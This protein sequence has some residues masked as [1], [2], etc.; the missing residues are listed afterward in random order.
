MIQKQL[1]I[2]YCDYA[3]LSEL[4][5]EWQPLVQEARGAADSAYA[6]YSRFCVGAAVLLGDG[7]IVTG[8]NQENAAYPSGLC[9][10]RVALFSAMH[11][12]PCCP[13]RA[14]AVAGRDA[15][16]RYVEASPCGACR[17]VMAEAEG[18][19]GRPMV[20]LICL[21]GGE[22]RL[23]RGTNSLLPFAFDALD[24]K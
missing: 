7:S 9:A 6:P 4:P 5:A 10:E 20:V 3:S 21:G 11:R 16:G 14:L 15:D 22:I 19:A 12:F 1:T 17:Q 13:V 24:G 2:D 18:I 8:S 23:L